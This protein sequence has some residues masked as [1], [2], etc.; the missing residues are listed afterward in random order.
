MTENEWLERDEWPERMLLELHKACTEGQ[1]RISERMLRLF[2]CACCRRVENVVRDD[3]VL[4]AIDVVERH[5]DGLATD[6]ELQLAGDAIERAL[7]ESYE[8]GFR[9]TPGDFNWL[10]VPI[11]SLHL[12]E[13]AAYAAGRTP[14]GILMGGWFALA[15]LAA[16]KCR[17]AVTHAA[18]EAG[19]DHQPVT[20]AV[21]VRHLCLLRD[22]LG[23]PFRPVSLNTAWPAWNDG[24][25]PK[26]AQ[27]IYEELAF[28]RMPILADALEEASCTNPDILNHC[29]SHEEHVRG[30]WVVDLILGKK[31]TFIDFSTIR[32]LNA[33]RF[34]SAV[35]DPRFRNEPEA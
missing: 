1:V 8:E 30:C 31:Q 28:E 9:I 15:M 25:I 2:C 7:E 35:F 5:V 4:K 22:C 13:A 34:R 16:M 10:V 17:L 18:S 12:I 3:R 23:N 21:L 20:Q 6:D 27:S 11:P 14:G 33:D 19:K 24:I 32:K 29:R 26:L